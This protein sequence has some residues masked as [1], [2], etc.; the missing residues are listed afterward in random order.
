MFIDVYCSGPAFTNAILIA[1]METKKAAIIDAPAGSAVHLLKTLKDNELTAEMLL[2]THSHWDH[3]VDAAKL[4][5]VLGIPIYVHKKDAP[6][7]S[8][9][10]ADGLPLFIEVPEVEP[11]HFLE[12]GMLLDLGNIQIEV[13]HTPGHSPGGVS[14]YI[15]SESLLISGDTL[16]KGSIGNLS[17]PQSEP[18]KMWASLDRL[19]KLPPETR[20]IAGHGEETTIG[21]ET[22]LKHAK[23]TFGE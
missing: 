19:A 11:D 14:F 3:F 16:F 2:L 10:G 5:K 21:S 22:W 4:K 7:L 12:D 8:Y 17:F 20:V 6:N 18:E 13:I 23:Q 9:P 1:C 15:P